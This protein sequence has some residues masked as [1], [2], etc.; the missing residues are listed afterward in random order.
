LGSTGAVT[1]RLPVHPDFAGPHHVR[2]GNALRA[3][4]GGSDYFR[5]SWNR[6]VVKQMTR[7]I[8][9]GGLDVAASRITSGNLAVYGEAERA[10]GGWLGTGSAVLT[11]GGYTAP[12]VAAQALA[13]RCDGVVVAAGGHPCLT[14]AAAGSGLPWV[15]DVAMDRLA[16][17]LDD[18]G[19]SRPLVM[20]DGLGALTGRMPDMDAWLEVLPR[21]GWLL[22]DDAHGIGT[23][24]QRGRGV[25]ELAG[26]RDRRVI[27]A[28]TLS[29]A[30]GLQ[31]GVVAGPAWVARAVWSGSHAARSSTPIP[32]MYAAAIPCVLELLDRH[33]AEWRVRLAGH[34]S[35]LAAALV[36]LKGAE[37]SGHAGA[38]F[39]VAP[40]DARR[41]RTMERALIAAGIQPPFIRYPGGP[42]GGL[43]RFAL[44][45]THPTT[46]VRR[47][48]TT[49]E[50]VC[51]R[52]PTGY[53]WL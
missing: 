47:L 24:G 50:A 29:K 3:Y 21:A 7:E 45:A 38:V 40:I 16:T 32:P 6:T 26:C 49:L 19:W 46:L 28:F 13:A 5:L 11:T 8:G 2:I 37:P 14:D 41:A 51:G 23:V 9:R 44:S 33:G 4:F 39:G 25:M 31:G 34:R 52:D 15:K 30:F 53:R 43:F 48:A 20:M 10:L 17:E 36:G 22:L 42:V 27:R 18:R 35:L 12:L 1:T